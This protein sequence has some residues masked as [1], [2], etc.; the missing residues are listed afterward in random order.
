MEK[1]R[2]RWAFRSGDLMP[3]QVETLGFNERCC[4]QLEKQGLLWPTKELAEEARTKAL[5]SLAP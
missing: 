3:E 1:Q 5:S 2:E 4:R